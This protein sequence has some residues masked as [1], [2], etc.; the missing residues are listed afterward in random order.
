MSKVRKQMQKKLTGRKG[1]FSKKKK[2]GRTSYKRQMAQAMDKMR[3]KQINKQNEDAVVSRAMQAGMKLHLTDLM[4]S[5]KRLQIV[6]E[7]AR[8][9]RELLRRKRFDADLAIEIQL[10]KKARLEAKNR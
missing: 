10:Q 3:T 8:S 6:A 5:G 4:E 2:S 7:K 9:K 1:E